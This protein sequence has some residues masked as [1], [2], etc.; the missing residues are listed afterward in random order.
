MESSYFH[1]SSR[2]MEQCAEQRKELLLHCCNQVWMKI[3]WQILWNA[4]AVCETFNISC[5]GGK[6]P[7]ERRFGEY[8]LKVRSFRSEQ[9]LNVIRFLRKTSQGSINL[10]RKSYP[11]HSSDIHCLWEESGKETFRL[12]TLRREIDAPRLDAREIS[13]IKKG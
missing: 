2:R 1:T 8:H 12:Q 7:Y 6:T 11:E 4:V 5:L 13:N 10:V 3:G 9:W